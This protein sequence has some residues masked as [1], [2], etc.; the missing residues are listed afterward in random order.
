MSRLGTAVLV[1]IAAA[2]GAMGEYWY[3]SQQ[4]AMSTPS[5]NAEPAAAAER[6]ILYYRDPS[7]APFWSATPKTDAQGRDYVPVYDDDE[8]S[9][10]AQP[11]KPQVAGA[12]RKI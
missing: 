3:A 12:E 4:A 9:T 1:I 7:G 5:L 2:V 11:K 10:L 8:P 6:T